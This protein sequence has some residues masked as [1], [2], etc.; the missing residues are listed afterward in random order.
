MEAFRREENV[1][2]HDKRLLKRRIKSGW[3][4]N[5]KIKEFSVW[6]QS[7][8]NRGRAGALVYRLAG[9][10]CPEGWGFVSQH[11]ILDG[12]E[13]DFE[14]VEILDTASIALKLQYK[15]MLYIRKLKPTLNKQVES[16]LFCLIIQNV[17]QTD[18]VTRDIQKYLKKGNTKKTYKN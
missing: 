10:S 6:I 7:K 13:I 16:E 15:E 17:Q 9:D 14:G 5:E 3:L 11:N 18:S 8:S 1:D 2:K 4:N 12:H